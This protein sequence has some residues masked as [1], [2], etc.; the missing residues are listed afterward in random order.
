MSKPVNQ[1]IPIFVIS[2]ARAP[3][4]R[5]SIERHLSGLGL[6]YEIVDA[7]DGKLLSI[8]QQ[9]KLLAPG[10]SYVP[11]VIGCYLSHVGVYQ[12]IVDRDIS[13]ALVLED[14]ARLNPK[15]VPA[16]ITGDLTR[17]F[18]YC[19]LDCDDV[20]EN[21]PV[22]YDLDSEEELTKGFPVYS[23]NIGPAL[24]HAYLMTK[25]GAIKRIAHAWP[26]KKPVDVYSQLSYIPVIK[27]CV[28]PKGAWVSEYSRQSFTSNRNETE[29]LRFR[30]LRKFSIAFK[31]RDWLKL[32]PLKGLFAISR[33]KRQ[34][35][36][37]PDRR[38]RAMPTGRNILHDQI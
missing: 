36:L 20:S 3:E 9:E 8:D 29:P 13:V 22:Y 26:I 4:R 28:D 19:L 37:D 12:K 17:N 31:L 33:L 16:L 27:V 15:I 1:A 24:L 6:S 32:K 11:G 38:W 35:V 25:E 34:G 14:D 2:L 5:E 23:T 18:D 10:V 7:V 21:T 30:Y